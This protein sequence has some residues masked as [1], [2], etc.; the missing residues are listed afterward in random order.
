MA[1]IVEELSEKYAGRVVFA[2][3]DVDKNPVTAHQCGVMSIPTF[4]IT[5]KGK[6][7]DVLVGAMAKENFERQ[8]LRY[9]QQS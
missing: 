4:V 6:I 3:V 9:L 2:K 5:N 1:P 8:I 7:L